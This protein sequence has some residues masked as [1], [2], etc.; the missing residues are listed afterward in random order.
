MIKLP[1]VGPAYKM[2][3]KVISS[4]N[5]I[6][7]YPQTIEYPNGSRVAALMPTPGLKKIYQGLASQV[8]C[9]HVLSNGAL[10]AV[11]GSKLYH[12]KSN[13]FNLVEI[14]DISASGV[15]RVADN[16]RV[17]LLVNGTYTYSFDLKTL[18]LTRLSGSSV[19]RSTHVVFLDG[20]F[21]VNKVK[22]GQ[23]FWSDLYSTNINALSY[24]TAEST[25][26]NITAIIK[27]NSTELWLFGSQSVERY[28]GSGAA[29]SPYARLSGGAMSFGCIAPD[30]IVALATG[31]IWL[32]VSEFGGSQI[33]MSNGGVPERISTHAIEEEIAS[34]S[35]TTDAIAYAY[36]SEGHVFYVISFPSADIT[37]CYDVSTGLWHQ[38]SYRNE[39]GLHERH[40]SQHH[41]FFNNIHIVGDYQNGKLYQL[42]NNTFTDDNDL[43]LRE[44]TAQAVITD[45]KLTRF[46]QLQIIC[47]TAFNTTDQ[48]GGSVDPVPIG[49]VGAT[50]TIL[51][52]DFI[53]QYFFT[54][55]SLALTTA[56]A[57]EFKTIIDEDPELN[58][59]FSVSTADSSLQITNISNE[60]QRFGISPYMPSNPSMGAP[61]LNPTA[62]ID[63]FG[64]LTFCLAPV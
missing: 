63:E 36:Q 30:S 33:V 32:G 46:N 29:N 34:Y 15:V 23:F 52:P 41:A 53:G 3:S 24:A 42:D 21:V 13:A 1:L 22:T 11:I 39:Q 51:I 50:T 19:P 12:S 14:G 10:L 17:A 5:C 26:D 44:R 2:Q 43:I 25:P 40:R 18:V 56:S 55:N 8:R 28:Y 38:R 62:D 31:V 64:Q 47:E 7:W 61:Q 6:N 48:S 58:L 60:Y 45:Q 49:C 9:L 4:Q 59:L 57:E 20:R 27:F 35:K 54:L 37:F 16:G